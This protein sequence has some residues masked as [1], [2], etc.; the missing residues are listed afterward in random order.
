MLSIVGL[1]TSCFPVGLIAVYFGM[2]ARRQA[3]ELGEPNS[4]NATLG[5]VG[6]ILGAVFGGLWGLLYLAYIGIMVFA[7]VAAAMG[8]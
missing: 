3:R 4:T 7:V 2:K 6:M 8:S 1:S 5:L